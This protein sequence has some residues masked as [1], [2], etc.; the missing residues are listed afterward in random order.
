MF[1]T[2]NKE[3]YQKVLSK[4]Q[5]QEKEDFIQFI[6]QIPFISHWSKNL[7]G[8]LRYAMDTVVINRGQKIIKEGE[9]CK[10]IYI[11]KS[12][13]YELIK[14]LGT[15]KNDDEDLKE[16][17]EL[18]RPLLAR[19]DAKRCKAMRFTKEW[20]NP[21]RVKRSIRLSILG[22][23]K[24]FGDNDARFN[25]DSSATVVANSLSGTL[26]RIKASEFLKHLKNDEEA[27]LRFTEYCVIKEK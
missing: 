21:S 10:Y 25:R 3:S 24:I 16:E 9:S 14:D 17:E 27:W 2:V 18:I 4:I 8:K 13:E 6:K 26:Y 1:A 12:G 15:D 7:L 22:E 20:H 11:V 5:K 19:E 23:C